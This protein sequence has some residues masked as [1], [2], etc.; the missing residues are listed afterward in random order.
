MVMAFGGFFNGGALFPKHLF[1]WEVLDR[2]GFPRENKSAGYFQWNRN[3]MLVVL[4]SRDVNKSEEFI[5]AS[6]CICNDEDIKEFGK[7]HPHLPSGA[8]S[9]H[10]DS[11]G[12]R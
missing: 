3:P 10:R 4:D 8:L 6:S 1:H 11:W 2:I 5:C 7:H 12:T 9:L